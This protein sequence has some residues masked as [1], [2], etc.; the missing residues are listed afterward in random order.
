M[1]LVATVEPN[2]SQTRLIADLQGWGRK[3]R[4]HELR[5]TQ[6]RYLLVKDEMLNN[7]RVS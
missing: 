6:K 3:S 4:K 2:E 7:P 1:E 5:K